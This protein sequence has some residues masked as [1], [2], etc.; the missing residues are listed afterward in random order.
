MNN[1]P[2]EGLDQEDRPHLKLGQEVRVVSGKHGGRTGT[3]HRVRSEGDSL[4]IELLEGGEQLFVDQG[5]IDFEFEW[6]EVS[7]F[8]PEGERAEWFARLKELEED[9]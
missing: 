6:A 2:T 5:E 8:M 1:D 9:Y 7:L 4:R 3:V